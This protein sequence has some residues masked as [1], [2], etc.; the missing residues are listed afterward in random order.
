MATTPSPWLVSTMLADLVDT[1]L[2][3]LLAGR[4]AD[5]VVRTLPLDTT[6][7]DQV[8][9]EVW[10]R[11]QER[12]G[13]DDLRRGLHLERRR[14][15]YEAA[16]AA[17]DFGAALRCLQDMA[18]IEGLYGKPPQDEDPLDAAVTAPAIGQIDGPPVM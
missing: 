13:S 15:L 14:R 6:Q 7:V 3:Q 16:L 1:V 11:I 9:R 18:K 8:L 17:D 5:E 12:T 2:D 4:A 10:S